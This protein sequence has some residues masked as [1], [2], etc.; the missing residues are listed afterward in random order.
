MAY[1]EINYTINFKAARA[2]LQSRSRGILEPF[3]MCQNA[4]PGN[5]VTRGI[6]QDA[7]SVAVCC[8]FRDG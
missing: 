1:K 7:F 6:R 2:Q 5:S 8:A 3:Q 4:I